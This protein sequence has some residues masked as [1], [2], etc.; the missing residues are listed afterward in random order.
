MSNFEVYWNPCRRMSPL[1]LS[2]IATL[3]FFL[4]GCAPITVR[5]DFDHSVNFNGYRTFSLMPGP[6]RALQNPLVVQQTRDAL[7]TELETKQ[8]SFTGDAAAADFVVDF[9]IGSQERMDTESLPVPYGGPWW[10]LDSWWGS[11]Y[12][13]AQVDQRLYREGTLSV[14]VFDAHS[15]KPVWHGSASKELTESDVEHS[16]R[17]IRTAVRSILSGFPPQ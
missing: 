16:Q 2:G 1:R 5:T 15:H 12:W 7:Q 4:A 14:D 13:G 9:T 3:A 6:R 11:A 17:P 10:N 8:F